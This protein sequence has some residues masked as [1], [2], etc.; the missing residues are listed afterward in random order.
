MA[1]KQ[2]QI[3]NELQDPILA[4]KYA[5]LIRTHIHE[6]FHRHFRFH[7]HLVELIDFRCRIHVAYN[8]IQLGQY[9]CAHK[10]LSKV[11]HLC[12]SRQTYF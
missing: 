11:S 4:L 10:T 3:A 9:E 6:Y 8:E 5:M 2:L 12:F 7:I 1:Q